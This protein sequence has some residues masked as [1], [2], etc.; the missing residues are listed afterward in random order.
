MRCVAV[1][2]SLLALGLGAGAVLG[3]PSEDLWSGQVVV[4]S[5]GDARAYNT[6]EA[7][8]GIVQIRPKC[9][10]DIN[11]IAKK[12]GLAVR[13]TA[14][15]RFSASKS[16]QMWVLYLRYW[17]EQYAKETGREPT[18]EVY[19]RIWNGGPTGWR[20]GTT[21]PYWRRVRDAMPDEAE[22]TVASAGTPA[23]SDPEQ[24]AGQT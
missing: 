20:K 7:A 9:L 17:G 19:A 1:A 10:A 11:R 14:S 21:R 23:K 4:E 16:R 12:Q 6:R 5:R 24:S 22:V 13:Y 18:D 3:D 8:A 2:A 15:D